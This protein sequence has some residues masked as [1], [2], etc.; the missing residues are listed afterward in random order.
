MALLLLI[1]TSVK[2]DKGLTLISVILND[3]LKSS[4]QNIL[5]LRVRV[6]IYIFW[7]GGEYNSFYNSY[8]FLEY[9]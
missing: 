2:S 8:L 5:P 3:L 1:W 6:S 9:T 7:D 4:P